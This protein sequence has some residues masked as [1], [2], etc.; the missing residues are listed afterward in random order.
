MPVV[1]S[2]RVTLQEAMPVDRSSFPQTTD[3]ILQLHFDEVTAIRFYL[4]TGGFFP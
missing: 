1:P 2:G 3:S 4:R